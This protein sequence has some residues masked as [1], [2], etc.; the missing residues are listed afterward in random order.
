MRTD[1]TCI[2]IENIDVE[3]SI[4]RET[5]WPVPLIHTFVHTV[6]SKINASQCSVIV[7]SSVQIFVP[8]PLINSLSWNNKGVRKLISKIV[9]LN[10][11]TMQIR[12]LNIASR[13]IENKNFT[14][15]NLLCS[16][17]YSRS[18]KMLWT[19]RQE[20]LSK[21]IVYFHALPEH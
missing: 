4:N 1:R 21:N 18:K 12:R 9:I 14:F 6:V 5:R 20:Q 11:F 19:L 8:C 10:N 15:S 3:G 16:Q 7:K 2:Y 13:M 17:I